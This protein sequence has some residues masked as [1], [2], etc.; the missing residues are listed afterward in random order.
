VNTKSDGGTTQQGLLP[1]QCDERGEIYVVGY[2]GLVDQ[3]D[4]SGPN[5]DN[6]LKT[7]SSKR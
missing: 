2:E 7:A 5:F 3:L 6:E 1:S 4:L